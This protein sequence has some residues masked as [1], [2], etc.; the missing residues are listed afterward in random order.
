VTKPLMMAEFR[1]IDSVDCMPW[2]ASG[3]RSPFETS[4]RV[5][6]TRSEILH[7]EL[8]KYPGADFDYS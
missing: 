5:S 3:N 1:K 7:Q 4:C 2:I 8:Q 6:S